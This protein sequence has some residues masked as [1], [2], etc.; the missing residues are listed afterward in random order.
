MASSISFLLA[1][2]GG[3]GRLL[4]KTDANSM[5]LFRGPGEF[6]RQSRGDQMK[7]QYVPD[8]HASVNSGDPCGQRSLLFVMGAEAFARACDAISGGRRKFAGFIPAPNGRLIE[9]VSKPG[10]SFVCIDQELPRHKV[11][12]SCTA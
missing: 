10:D 8:M 4:R 7:P 3:E 5:D 11:F 9:L 2:R 12:G 1:R 6:Q